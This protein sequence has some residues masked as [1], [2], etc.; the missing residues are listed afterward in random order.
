MVFYA[1]DGRSLIVPVFRA[2]LTGAS[3]ESGD[4]FFLRR[5]DARRGTPL[6]KPVRV[7]P[8]EVDMRAPLMTPDGRLVVP[9]DSGVKALDADTLRVI[10]RYPVSG[11]SVLSPDGSTLTIGTPDGGLACSTSPLEGCG[12]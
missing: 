12:R 7:A 1:P 4:A 2:R 11:G 3:M 10:R 9:A 6:G 8:Q 5:Y